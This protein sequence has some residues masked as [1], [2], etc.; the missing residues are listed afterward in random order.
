MK[1]EALSTFFKLD[2]PAWY[3]LHEA[4]QHF[5]IGNEVIRLYQPDVCPFGGVLP[6]SEDNMALLGSMI[7]PGTT[8]FLLGDLPPLPPGFELLHELPC[9]Q[10]VCPHFIEVSP[11]ERL[12]CLNDDYVLDLVDLVQLVQ[13]GYF[14]SKTCEMGEYFGIFQDGRLVA[15]AGE[16]MRM[17]DFTEV[18]AVV[19]HPDFGGRGYAKQLVAHVV[20]KNLEAGKIP[21]LHVAEHNTPAIGL[22]EKL[23]FATRRVIPLR[24]ISSTNAC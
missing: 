10:M 19:T 16:R 13:P 1:V 8:F 20:N 24:K 12:V 14:Q 18:S 3:S 21:Y 4:H 17:D 7:A 11:S 5:N 6:P 9:V 22:Y 23:G 15:A 2:S